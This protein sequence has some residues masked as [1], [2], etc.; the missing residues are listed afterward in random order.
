[1]DIK[2]S[3]K[4]GTI[5]VHGEHE[6][7]QIVDN[8]SPEKE[9]EIEKMRD[10]IARILRG[11]DGCAR[12]VTPPSPTLEKVYGELI[13]VVR[14]VAYGM[15][16]FDKAQVRDILSRIDDMEI[17]GYRLNSVHLTQK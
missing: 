11:M 3:L 4:D 15:I 5:E 8:Q 1:M 17:A 7:S 2:I 12:M 10:S 9:A 14:S 16:F 13:K 6:K